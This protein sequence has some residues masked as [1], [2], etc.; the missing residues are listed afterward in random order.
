MFFGESE[1]AFFKFADL[2]QNRVISKA[3]YP[4]SF[5]GI[6]KNKEFKYTEKEEGEIRLISCDISGMSSAKNNNDASVFTILRLIPNKSKTAYNKYVCYM[7][8]LEGGHSLTQALRIRKLYEEFDCN[9]IVIDTKS[10]GLGVF[11]C[12]STN[13]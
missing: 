12:L 4:K 13:L 11:D 6:L 10:F 8:S 2:E 5:Y 3:I 1:K 7:E 9:Y